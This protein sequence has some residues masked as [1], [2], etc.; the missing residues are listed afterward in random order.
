MVNCT[1]TQLNVDQYDFHID[2]FAFWFIKCKNILS[3]TKMGWGGWKAT[4]FLGFFYSQVLAW[5]K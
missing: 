4:I 3:A 2:P 1:P 5:L